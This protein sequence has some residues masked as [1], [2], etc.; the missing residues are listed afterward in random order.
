M[1]LRCIDAPSVATPQSKSELDTLTAAINVT[2][3]TN[4][5]Y[6]ISEL[7]EDALWLSKETEIDEV[8]ALRLSLLQWQSRP[9]ERLLQDGA[10]Y[11]PH[12]QGLNRPDDSLKASFL[13]STTSRSNLNYG[14]TTL[15]FD[16]QRTRQL[17]LLKLYASES[18]YLLQT[19]E[20]LV[21]Q[22]VSALVPTDSI[23]TLDPLSAD[24]TVE[25]IG[26]RV[27]DS[28]KLRTGWSSKG[29]T[30]FDLAISY[31][32]RK[33]RVLRRD[34][35]WSFI[36]GSNSDLEQQWSRTNVIETLSLLQIMLVI[37][38]L[39]TVL[40]PSSFIL[41]WFRFM[42]RAGYFQSL[43]IVCTLDLSPNRS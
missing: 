36:D 24:R 29:K 30:W 8:S 9:A 6:N 39:S 1:L 26:I 15:D 23:H 10:P 28:W 12:N 4:G 7:K 38:S 3:T 40:A 20:Y 2:P 19:T 21:A 14:R 34:S 37:G 43:D 32:E 25:E 42:D 33:L 35:G 13:L 11:E 22:G 41:D 17:E 31:L 5:R 16:S 27:L 18:Q